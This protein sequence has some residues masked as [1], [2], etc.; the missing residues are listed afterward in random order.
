LPALAVGTLA[1]AIGMLSSIVW[2]SI[3]L[4]AQARDLAAGRRSSM[5]RLLAI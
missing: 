3:R 2:C 1:V 5:G 4:G